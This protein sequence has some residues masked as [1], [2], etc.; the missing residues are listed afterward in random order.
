MNTKLQKNPKFN[1]YYRKHCKYLKVKGFRPKTVEAYARAIR[2]IGNHFNGQIDNLTSDQLI[3]YFHTLLETHSWS[4]AKLDIYGLQFFYTHILKKTWEDIPIIKPKKARRIPDIVTIDEVNKLFGATRI[5]S[6]KVFFFTV[7]TLGLRL[8]EGIN[9]RVGD[10]DSSHMRVH[11]REAKGNKDRLVP[12]PEKTLSV[13]RRFWLLH[14]HPSF[15]F[16]SRKRGMRN[17]HLVEN[18][19]GKA[20]IQTALKR[21]VAHIGIKKKYPATR[22]ATATPLI[23]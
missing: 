4:S 9:L 2:R 13:L 19:I 22:F 14:K 6:Y 12:L 8:S 1:K 11:I 5:I 16:P 17:A 3:D 23:S 15:I 7:Y 20:G 18:P 10:I 21:I